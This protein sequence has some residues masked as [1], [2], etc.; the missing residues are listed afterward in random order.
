MNFYKKLKDHKNY[1]MV[2]GIVNLTPDSFYD[3][4]KYN[5]PKDAVKYISKIIKQGADIIDIGAMSSRPGSLPIS[6]K[7][8]EKRL[9]SVL[10]IIRN[11]FPE[12]IISIDTYRHEIAE[13]SIKYGANIINDIYVDHNK[14]KMWNI[15]QKYNT[16]YIM[17]HMQGNP[18]NMQTKIHYENFKK[19]VLKFFNKRVRSLKKRGFEQIIIDP[20]FGFGKT[21]QQNY[22]LINIIDN[23]KDFQLPILIGVSRKSMISQGIDAPVHKTLS[24]TITANTICLMKGAQIIR[25]HDIKEAKETIKIYELYET[26]KT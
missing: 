5:T 9:L 16:P 11:K 3:G 8:E 17:M 22:Q 18:T 10:E 15:I 24:G 13:Q 20:G 4:G 23:L 26:N 12:I 6:L 1:H 7:E 21:I 14:E 2:M 25:V 19:D